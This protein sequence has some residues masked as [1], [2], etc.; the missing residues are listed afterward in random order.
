MGASYKMF[1]SCVIIL[2]RVLTLPHIL[3]SLS[4]QNT[5]H[6]RQAMVVPVL[7]RPLSPFPALLPSSCF[8]VEEEEGMVQ[9][10]ALQMICP[11][12]WWHLSDFGARP[13]KHPCGRALHGPC[14]PQE[15]GKVSIPA[16]IPNQEGDGF[17][18]GC[19]SL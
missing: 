14:V 16:C 3:D 7:C 5:G 6:E 17:A 11:R 19:I 9:V 15:H 10:T 12:G 1:C 13:A 18:D 8:S 2:H 4:P